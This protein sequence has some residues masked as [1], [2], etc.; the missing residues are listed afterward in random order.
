MTNLSDLFT[1]SPTVELIEP[2]G[3]TPYFLR[4]LR[5]LIRDG[6]RL[7]ELTIEADVITGRESLEPEGIL[8]L[9][10]MDVNEG[11]ELSR[12]TG[13]WV[14]DGWS[15]VSGEVDLPATWYVTWRGEEVGAVT[16][17]PTNALA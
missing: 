6:D 9:S 10:V 13:K 5:L 17:G 7:T 11:M 1:N 8:A 12:E 15:V 3:P 2:S 4:T 16:G 14:D